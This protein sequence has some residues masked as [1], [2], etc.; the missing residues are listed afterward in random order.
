MAFISGWAGPVST[1]QTLCVIFEN[2]YYLTKKHLSYLRCHMEASPF[3]IHCT[4]LML[5]NDCR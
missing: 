3:G 1:L 2:I 5:F 4:L